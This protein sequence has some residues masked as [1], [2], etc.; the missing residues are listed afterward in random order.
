MFY[1]VFEAKEAM[2]AINNVK[3]SQDPM[4]QGTFSS[5]HVCS[6][7]GIPQGQKLLS[8]W[9]HHP[10]AALEGPNHTLSDFSKDSHCSVL[11]VCYTPR[12]WLDELHFALL[13]SLP[14]GFTEAN[15]CFELAHF[16]VP[17]KTHRGCLCLLCA[18]KR[19]LQTCPAFFPLHK[20]V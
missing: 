8:G 14:D 6:C 11:P 16:S 20:Q 19:L 13:T 7:L 9:L 2:L 1:Q 5:T 10:W 15:W 4:V 18:G 17:A 12:F 3:N